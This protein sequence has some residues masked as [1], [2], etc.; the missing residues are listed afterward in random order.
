MGNETNAGSTWVLDLQPSRQQTFAA[1][2]VAGFA[3]AGFLIV[4]PFAGKPFVRLNAFFPSLDA[5]V[6]VTDFVTAVLLFTQFSISRARSLLALASG[7]LFTALIVIP[8]ALTFSGAFSSNG[9]LGANIQTGSWL[10]IFWHLGFGTGLLAYALLREKTAAIAV[11]QRPALPV[12]VSIA[13][14]LVLLVCILTWLATAGATLLPPIILD[15][16]R[17]SPVVHYPIW[18]TIL[19]SAAAIV[20]LAFRRER[21]ELDQWLMVVALV[22]IGELVLSGLVATI[23]FSFGFYAARGLS[24]VTSS[25]VL[26]VLLAE[27]T[28]LYASLV[29]SN[30]ML[31]R[32]RDSKLMNLE[33]MAASITHEVRQPLTAMASFGQA[34]VSFLKQ[35]PP[36]IE[37]AVL[38]VND[39]VAATHRADEIFKNIRALFGQSETEKS[40]LDLNSVTLETLDSLKLDLAKHEIETEV[41]LAPALPPVLASKTQLQEV[42]V[43]LLGNA[44]EAMDSVQQ[45]RKIRLATAPE[46]NGGVRLE[47]S[48]TGRGFVR[49]PR[50]TIFDAFVTTKPQGMGLGLALCRLIIMRHGGT[51]T[52]QPSNPHGAV[53]TVILPA[54]S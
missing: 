31:Q 6:F 7:Y 15:S 29:R 37:E 47:V 43:N 5:I 12:I 13:V 41:Q 30:V 4:L 19:V 35:T 17:I 23:R 25:I 9:L 2:A 21:S 8:H 44:I 54:A 46:Q 20:V 26:V 52:A 36:K 49:Q 27:T 50:E 33:V 24:L 45:A 40:Y 39:M 53:F 34:A 1:F 22:Y 42:I 38:T 32:E 51:I 16:T 48:D 14:G 10:F 11:T 3:L 18:F 28:R